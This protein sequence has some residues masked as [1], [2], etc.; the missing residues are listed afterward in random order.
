MAC[1]EGEGR[2]S[3]AFRLFLPLFI[4]VLLAAFPQATNAQFA[5]D[6]GGSASLESGYEHDGESGD[7]VLENID[8]LWLSVDIAKTVSLFLQGSFVSN[9]DR[10]YLFDADIARLS[11]KLSR[12]PLMDSEVGVDVGRFNFNDF[13]GYLLNHKAD[14]VRIGFDF[15]YAS[16]SFAAAYTGFVIKPNSTI[17]MSLSD[18][19]DANDDGVT[20]APPRLIGEFLSRFPDAVFGQDI[21][22]SG[23][24]Q[25]DLRKS[26]DLVTGGK[27][28]NTQYIGLGSEGSISA[29]LFLHVF[30]YLGFGTIGDDTYIL[31]NFEGLGLRWYWEEFFSSRI[32]ARLLRSSGDKNTTSLY[33]G[34]KHWSGAFLPISNLDLG[35]VFTPRMGNITL[36]DFGYSMK[37]IKRLQTEVRG[38]MFFRTEPGAISEN[39]IDAADTSDHFLGPELDLT[40]SFRLFSDAGLSLGIG[41]FFPASG[42]AGAFVDNSPRYKA[43]IKF[44][45]TF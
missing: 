40:A 19:A 33:E 2:L 23:I 5:F 29:R 17:L 25:Q 18:S 31:S 21:V 10:P 41:S 35:I 38:I 27:R 20:F 30:G 43:T 37:P 14:G 26:A 6:W 34:K 28:V 4:F 16:L 8:S 24:A 13:S 3:P 32:Q 42:S 15:P 39:G 44:N 45:M 22:L 7:P 11:F 1:I 9:L 36:V 12:V